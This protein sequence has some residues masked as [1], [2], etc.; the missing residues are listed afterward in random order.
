MARGKKTGGRSF[1]V[2]NIYGTGRPKNPVNIQEMQKANRLKLVE[3]FSNVLSLHP[4]DFRKRKEQL[5][6]QQV[7]RTDNSASILELMALTFIDYAIKKGDA[8]KINFM[9][10][11][12]AG[13]PVT[14]LEHSGDN[15][16]PV[17]ISSDVLKNITTERILNIAERI[18]GIK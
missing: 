16:T 13:R 6:K 15:E 5:Q 3:V 18:A 11:R 14:P 12:V 1:Q 17:T 7:K 2:G 10:D 8:T 4:A 9:L